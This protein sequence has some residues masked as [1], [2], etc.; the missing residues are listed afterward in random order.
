M[1]PLAKFQPIPVAHFISNCL[2][3][4]ASSLSPYL[5]FGL[6]NASLATNAELLSATEWLDGL[7]FDADGALLPPGLSASGAETLE[8]MLRRMKEELKGQADAEILA[9]A[10]ST[11]SASRIPRPPANPFVAAPP[12]PA[13]APKPPIGALERPQRPD[14]SSSLSTAP[15]SLPVMLH[16]LAGRLAKGLDES[17]QRVGEGAVVGDAMQLGELEAEGRAMV[18]GRVVHEP[19]EGAVEGEAR[20][21]EA[22]IGGGVLWMTRRAGRSDRERTDVEKAGVMLKTERG[23]ALEVV[24]WDFFDDSELMMAVKA[25][26]K[27]GKPPK[28]LPRV[29]LIICFP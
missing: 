9:A 4:D 19:V 1:R 7:H 11:S 15:T 8:A 25:V 29:K 22:W 17:I 12:A 16:L 5:N 3:P 6:L 14:K 21:Y 26:G 27:D 20:L 18:R 2:D 10:A 24:E 23:D 28:P 13:S